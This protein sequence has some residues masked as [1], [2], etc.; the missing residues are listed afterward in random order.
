MPLTPVFDDRR[1][2]IA[3]QGK[4]VIRFDEVVQLIASARAD[5]V[6]RT[7]PMLVD[8]TGATTDITEEDVDRLA[9]LVRTAV[10]TQG[11]RG[12]VAIAAS[13]DTLYARML[14]YE[15]KCSALG[16]NVIRVFRQAPDAARWL[17]IVGG[18]RNYL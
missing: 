8:A 13:D 5:I 12:L 15:T 4:G 17:D 14:A 2:R 16:V 9:A 3:V 11:P 7:W 6:R 10:E 1:R 18:A